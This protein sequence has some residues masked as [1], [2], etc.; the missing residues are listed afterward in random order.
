MR[1][2]LLAAFA[3]TILLT[4]A[5]NG[6]PAKI[7]GGGNVSA[8]SFMSNPLIGTIFYD[9]DKVRE[10]GL[11]ND[12]DAEWRDWYRQALRTF[13]TA[14]QKKWPEGL[15]GFSVTF[16]GDKHFYR[17]QP[18][19]PREM[20]RLAEQEYASSLVSVLEELGGT[21]KPP[22]VIKTIQMHLVVDGRVKA[23]SMW[24]DD[25]A[26]KSRESRYTTAQ[27]LAVPK[28]TI[29]QEIQNSLPNMNPVLLATIDLNVTGTPAYTR[30][31]ADPRAEWRVWYARVLAHVVATLRKSNVEFAEL[32]L[33]IRNDGTVLA[34]DVSPPV[35]QAS[36]RAEAI[37]AIAKALSAQVPEFR[38]PAASDKSE[39][40]LSL[41]KDGSELVV[42]ARDDYLAEYASRLAA[43]RMKLDQEKARRD[44]QRI[45]PHITKSTRAHHQPGDSFYTYTLEDRTD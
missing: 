34:C 35:K 25:A 17:V 36:S 5:A 43:A 14:F 19:S 2:Q 8:A 4:T 18:Q 41:T 28:D 1:R 29:R 40:V 32:E 23:V 10:F 12:S 3:F 31:L 30:E 27:L 13:S 33:K 16:D 6:E 9:P 20:P 38:F 26:L 45:P 15:A 37:K 21:L 11:I 44:A 7:S 24:A 39:I 42:H 22:P